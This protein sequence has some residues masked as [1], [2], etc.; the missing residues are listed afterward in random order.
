MK[1]DEVCAAVRALLGARRER[2]QI[3]A[4][5]ISSLDV[6]YAVQA[7]VARELGGADVW[8]AAGFGPNRGVYFSP[9]VTSTVAQSGAR[10][11]GDDFHMIGLE[12]EIVVELSRAV[13]ASE[14]R[15]RRAALMEN[16]SAVYAAIE[17]VDTRLQHWSDAPNLAKVADNM[18]S[19]GLVLGAALPDWRERDLRAPGFGLSINGAVAAPPRRNG[20]GEI[21]D[22]VERWLDHCR[23]HAID[24][25]AGAMLTTGSCTGFVLGAADDDVALLRDS[26]ELVHARF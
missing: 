1:A 26:E 5:A 4:P 25:P 17:I 21:F 14:A 22:I 12:G 18:S 9:V 23:A 7:E 19:G 15:F 13:A 11:G 3:V 20:L 16:V 10:F 6:A 24:L 2:T 8:K